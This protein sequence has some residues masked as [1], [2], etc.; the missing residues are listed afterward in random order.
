MQLQ[1]ITNYAIRIVIELARN[2]KMNVK[3]LSSILH[4]DRHTVVKVLDKLKK[5]EIVSAIQGIAGG[6][7][8]RKDIR[9]IT[10]F[11]II[12]IME[13]KTKVNRCLEEDG[14]CSRYATKTCPVR[15]IYQDIQTMIE[16]EFSKQTIYDLIREGTENKEMRI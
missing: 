4:L 13:S 1:P 2:K 7:E 12:E 9:E 15:P 14:Y 16:A 5:A 6:F 11:H 8:L 10:L 3:E